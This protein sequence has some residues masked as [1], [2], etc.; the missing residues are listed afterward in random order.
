MKVSDMKK[1]LKNAHVELY[2]SRGS[3][4]ECLNAS[5]CVSTPP[6]YEGQNYRDPLISV[7]FQANDLT[8]KMQHGEEKQ[9]SAMIPLHKVGHWYAGNVETEA[10]MWYGGTDTKT[11]ERA[12]SFF[13]IVKDIIA[14]YNIRYIYPNCELSQ[15]LKAL[16]YLGVR[17][18]KCEIEREDSFSWNQDRM[19]NDRE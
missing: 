6:K 7:R 15:C 19:R 17:V 11:P 14:K 10:R 2:I 4:P 18:V 16:E 1:A 3:L 13:K 12:E 9:V 5:L 8:Y